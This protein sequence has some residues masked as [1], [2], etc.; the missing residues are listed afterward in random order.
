MYLITVREEVGKQNLTK[1]WLLLIVLNKLRKNGP[2]QMQA[3]VERKRGSPEI[4]KLVGSEGT[5]VLKPK[6]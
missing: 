5:I 4:W 2:G 3:G 6:W 1:C